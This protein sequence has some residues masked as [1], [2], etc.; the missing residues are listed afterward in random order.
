M[1]TELV[2]LGKEVRKCNVNNVH[3]LPLPEFGKK[4]I[5]SGKNWLIYKQK[6][7]KIKFRNLQFAENL[8]HFD[9]TRL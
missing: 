9:D 1:F 6:S 8:L 5:S 2:N 3:G 4:E 7:K